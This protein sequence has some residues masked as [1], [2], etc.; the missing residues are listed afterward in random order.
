MKLVAQFNIFL[1]LTVFSTQF[2]KLGFGLVNT[3]LLALLPTL[4]LAA[5]LLQIVAAVGRGRLRVRL[6]GLDLC[7][8]LFFAL[9]CIQVLNP[10][11]NIAGGLNAMEVGFRGLHQRTFLGSVYVI[12]RLVVC[13]DDRY[14]S[15][16]RILT[17]CIAI[18]A[19]YGAAQTV[20]GALPFEDRFRAAVIDNDALMEELYMKRAVGFMN[21]PFLFGISSVIGVWGATFLYATSTKW[22]QRT[23]WAICGAGCLAGLYLSG[24]RSGYLAMFSAAIVSFV[25]MGSRSF[26]LLWSARFVIIAMC[27][28]AFVYIVRSASDS[29]LLLFANERFSSIR[30][31]LNPHDFQDNNFVTRQAVAR[32][33]IPLVFERP[34]GYGTG[35]FNGGSNSQGVVEVRG[36]STFVDNEFISLTLELGVV[37]L[38]L[39]LSILAI[40]SYRCVVFWRRR[41]SP[42]AI[43]PLTCITGCAMAGFG[44]QWLG[45]YPVNIHFWIFVALAGNLRL[46]P[47]APGGMKGES[48]RRLRGVRHQPQ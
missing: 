2:V 44:G 33:A 28:G 30:Q 43:L 9:D 34:L 27:C 35:I 46:P 7:V 4:L 21:S 22:K 45:E 1:C 38:A 13:N 48:V 8:M 23:I 17:G 10:Y 3:R 32:G 41:A 36:Y 12:A 40:V 19:L 25:V 47:Q 16:V 11:L 26:R 20:F 39:F 5:M 15:T 6:D 14:L 42:F 37:G 31:F 24:S 29:E 18:S